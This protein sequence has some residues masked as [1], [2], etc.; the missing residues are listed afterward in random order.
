MMWV[1]I[2]ARGLHHHTELARSSEISV[3]TLRLSHDSV[4]VD[5]VNGA[6]LMLHVSFIVYDLN[7]HPGHPYCY[8]STESSVE[9]PFLKKLPKTV[10]L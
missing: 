4:Y 10:W 7:D 9:A 2:T 1:C 6:S 5:D 8:A 3:L